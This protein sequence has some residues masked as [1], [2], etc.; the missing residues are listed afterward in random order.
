MCCPRTRPSIESWI[1]HSTFINDRDVIYQIDEYY[2]LTL[3]LKLKRELENPFQVIA[4]NPFRFNFQNPTKISFSKTSNSSSFA[5]KFNYWEI[6]IETSSP[7]S[8]WLLHINE[9]RI[10]TGAAD[11]Y[12]TLLLPAL[13]PPT[14]SSTHTHTH[15]TPAAPERKEA[16][17]I[18]L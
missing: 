10:F 2:R 16:E 8:L 3:F 7:N 18:L 1:K 11:P 12:N 4:R 6:C 17:S 9:L 13:I 5:A 14:T 15:K